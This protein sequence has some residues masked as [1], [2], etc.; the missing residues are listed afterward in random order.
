MRSKR[1]DWL[2]GRTTPLKDRNTIAA[3]A[4]TGSIFAFMIP[5][6]LFLQNVK[7]QVQ[8]T[9]NRMKQQMALW[10][11]IDLDFYLLQTRNLF[12]LQYL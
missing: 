5:S 12:L 2:T 9:R 3:T 1:N 7:I 10:W 4:L 8:G 6:Q 11:L